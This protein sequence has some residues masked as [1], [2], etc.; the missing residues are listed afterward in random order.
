MTRPATRMMMGGLV[1]TAFAFALSMAATAD[2]PATRPTEDPDNRSGYQLDAAWPYYPEGMQFEM[3]SGVAVDANGVI[4]LFTRDVEHWAA[5][6]LA[7]GKE[8]GKSSVSMFDSSGKYLGK[9]GTSDERGFALGAHTIYVE[10]DGNIWTADRDGHVVKK[11]TPDGELLLTLGTFAKPGNGPDQLNGP[12]SVVVQ[13]N[14]N[15]VVGD[16][17]WNSRLVFYT[18]EGKFIK[19]IGKWGREPGEFNSVH[20]MA[21]TA[22]G[23]L[24][25]VD[26]CGGN[27]HSYMT[28]PG[29]IKEHRNHREP[30]C[31]SRIQILDADG[32]YLGEWNHIAPLS[33]AVYGN[34]VY[35][36]DN[37]NSLK[38]LDDKTGEVLERMDNLAIYIHQMAL[39]PN[40][41]IFTAS[42]YPEHKGEK[43]GPEGPSHHRWTR[44]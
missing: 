1:A 14:G 11:H 36:S 42:V 37:Y 44:P 27:L 12:T 9:W 2:D 4:Y 40:G 18:P 13:A 22:D 16:G 20:A 15:I 21:Q 34:K 39:A 38:V 28:V 3:G 7:M 31:K 8:M 30:D 19:T 17:Y 32:N 35:A 25:V 24:L 41:D 23:R 26:F 43:R 6:P 33:V 5:H 29:Q 10:A